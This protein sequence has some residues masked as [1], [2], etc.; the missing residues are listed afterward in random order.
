MEKKEKYQ[1]ISA[2]KKSFSEA[3]KNTVGQ[4]KQMNTYIAVG[5][6]KG[7]IYVHDED[8]SVVSYHILLNIV[9]VDY[10]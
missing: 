3:M 9:I 4:C 7:W 8:S 5:V 6:I 10:Q 2:E 1:Y